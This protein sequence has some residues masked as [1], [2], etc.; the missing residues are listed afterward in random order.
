MG[1]LLAASKTET[2]NNS[3]DRPSQVEISRPEKMLAV[4]AVEW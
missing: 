3:V 4:K 1:N 2:L